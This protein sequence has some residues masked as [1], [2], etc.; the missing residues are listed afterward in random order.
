MKRIYFFG[1]IFLCVITVAIAFKDKEKFLLLTKGEIIEVTVL[2]IPVPCDLRNRKI[3][4]FFRFEYDNKIYSKNLKNEY[5]ESLVR[6]ES[7]LLKTN[8]EKS[9]FIYTDESITGNLGAS[10]VLFLVGIFLVFKGSKK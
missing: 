2:D 6:S 7:I 8:K 4:P 9:L 3:K 1:G 10:I 5:C